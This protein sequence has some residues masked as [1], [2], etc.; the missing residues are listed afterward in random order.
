MVSAHVKLVGT[1]IVC[2]YRIHLSDTMCQ[3]VLRGIPVLSTAVV[4]LRLLR[5]EG[6]EFW[7]A[8]YNSSVVPFIQTQFNNGG[9]VFR[10]DEPLKKKKQAGSK[11]FT[12]T[13][14]CTSSVLSWLSTL[15]ATFTVITF[16]YVKFYG[17][18]HPQP[19]NRLAS[20]LKLGA[21]NL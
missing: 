14:S 10:N 20:S 13:V 3:A 9:C 21:V 11:F 12:V 1:A 17:I 18:Q 5:G 4:I 19:C 8:W 7:R 16:F 2:R 6:F 15:V